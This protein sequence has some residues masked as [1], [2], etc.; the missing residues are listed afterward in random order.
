VRVI[1]PAQR[2]KT[3]KQ[4]KYLK[5][6]QTDKTKNILAGKKQ[7]KRSTGKKTLNPEKA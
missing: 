4:Y 7:H 1:K 2:H 5:K 3:Q 6:H